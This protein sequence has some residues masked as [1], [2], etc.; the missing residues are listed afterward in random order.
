[1]P[2]IGPRYF[3]LP[4]CAACN[5]G[6]QRAAFLVAVQRRRTWRQLRMIIA[7]GL[8]RGAGEL[9]GVNVQY[10][11]RFC[12]HVENNI[13]TLRNNPTTVIVVHEKEETRTTRE[14]WTP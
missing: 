14:G 5:C 9:R 3:G 6:I 12:P 13:T 10:N 4:T 2:T 8:C 1:M 7:M 11:R